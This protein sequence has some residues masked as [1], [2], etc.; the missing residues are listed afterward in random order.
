MAK[1][2]L[3]YEGLNILMTGIKSGE[4]AVGRVKESGIVPASTIQGVISLANIPKGAQERLVI[5][6]NET[7]RKA[8]TKEQI[9]AGDTGKEMDTGKMYFVVDDNKLATDE[10]WEVYS[11][12]SATEASHAT[13][14][15]TATKATNDSEGNN[16]AATYI[17][18]EDLVPITESEIRA[19][20]E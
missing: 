6:P 5:V 2:V 10:G 12:G 20:F 3:L 16:I 8:L 15:D 14:A 11:A 7:A 1:K 4:I 13:T 9:Q 19:M 18:S 17:K